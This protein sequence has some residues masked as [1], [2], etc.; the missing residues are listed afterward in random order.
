MDS[1]MYENR[2]KYNHKCACTYLPC[3]FY[4]N[5]VACVARE[6]KENAFP[7]CL[8]GLVQERGGCLPKMRPK[9]SII[10]RT[11]EEMS[12]TCAD[13]MVDTVQ[14][15]RDALFCLPA[16]N[17]AIRTYEI[18][19]HMQEQGKVDFSQARFVQ[20]DEWLDLKDKSEN[21]AAFLKTHFFN[22]LKIRSEQ[23]MLFQTE[24]DDLDDECERMDTFIREAGGID[25]MLLGIG[26]NGHIGLNEPGESFDS[27]AKVVTLS[28]TTKKVGQKY[29]A[30][31][32]VLSR[33]IT[34]GMR[35]VFDAKTVVLQ[36]GTAGKAEI[37][38]KLYSSRPS[39]NLP[40]TVMFH[41]ENGIIV[42]DED[43]ASLLTL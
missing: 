8:E 19:K 16:G 27:G 5:C 37:M 21:C 10:C 6:V 11:F 13:L 41:L 32:M 42:M 17:T 30:H 25:F 39:I 35:Q 36:A 12:Q 2:I 3:K 22:P 43:A 14:K 34:L 15:K 7:R 26:M 38:A 18:L 33:G 23:I 24:T 29:F 40:A 28:D 9:M 31:G 1:N 4:G 20:L